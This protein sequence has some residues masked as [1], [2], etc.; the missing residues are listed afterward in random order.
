LVAKIL[1]LNSL[2]PIFCRSPLCPTH[3]F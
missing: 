2:L 1:F 3:W